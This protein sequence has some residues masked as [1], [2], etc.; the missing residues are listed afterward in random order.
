MPFTYV[1][2]CITEAKNGNILDLYESDKAEFSLKDFS[3]DELKA[4]D[5][6]G[7]NFI[8]KIKSKYY[9]IRYK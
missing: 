4:Q 2:S 1:Y 7:L 9:N 8:E 3:I 5:D 6:L